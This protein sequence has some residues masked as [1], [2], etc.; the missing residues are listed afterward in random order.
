MS[1]E[2]SERQDSQV[3]EPG[4]CLVHAAEERADLDEPVDAGELVRA[5]AQYPMR[6]LH[7]CHLVLLLD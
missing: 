6:L 3:A 7:K 4:H 2:A 5:V 1:G